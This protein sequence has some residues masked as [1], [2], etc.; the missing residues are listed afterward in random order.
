M[1]YFANWHGY[2]LLNWPMDRWGV[3]LSPVNGGCAR[4]ALDVGMKW[5]GDNDS[6]AGKFDHDVFME[7]LDEMKPYKESCVFIA[8]PDV[9]GDCDATMA[10]F[11]KYANGIRKKGF[12]VAL[13][14]QDGQENFEMPNCD[15][16][17]VGGTTAWKMG[18]GAGACIQTAKSSGRWVHV[19]RVNS[20]KRIRHFALLGADSFDGTTISRGPKIKMRM[21][22]WALRQE[23]LLRMPGH[24]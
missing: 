2:D 10:R 8:A 23:M 13:V 11:K 12:P 9:L 6:F 16:L 20:R 5:C 19:G 18:P 21:L 24:G 3:L 15:V 4:F 14:A 22:D 7:W 17:F 1:M